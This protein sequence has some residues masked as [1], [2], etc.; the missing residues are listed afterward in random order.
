M[1]LAFWVYLWATVLVVRRTQSSP[2]CVVLNYIS[3]LAKHGPVSE[4]A[5]SASPWFLLLI[6][7]LSS[8]LR[9]VLWN[10]Q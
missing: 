8:L 2:L 5:G 7:G 1:R 4:L 10:S 3:K 9:Y 6:F